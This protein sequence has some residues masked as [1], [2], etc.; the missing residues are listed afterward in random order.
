MW[1]SERTRNSR[2]I[3]LFIRPTESV[4][5][6][7]AKRPLNGSGLKISLTKTLCYKDQRL[8]I[9]M[10]LAYHLRPSNYSNRCGVEWTFRMEAMSN[11]HR[12]DW[13]PCPLLSEFGNQTFVIRVAECR[14]WAHL[15]STLKVYQTNLKMASIL[16]IGKLIGSFRMKLLVHSIVFPSGYQDNDESSPVYDA[17]LLI[18]TVLDTVLEVPH[19]RSTVEVSQ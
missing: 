19:T 14:R 7:S 4:G 2:L 6:W 8:I 1:L 11:R 3:D 10:T 13:K 9:I 12:V 18:D 17:W 16:L 15:W 5:Q